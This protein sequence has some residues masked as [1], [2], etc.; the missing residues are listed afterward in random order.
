MSS[1]ELQLQATWWCNWK[2]RNNTLL[3]LSMERFQFALGDFCLKR[4]NFI[5][6]NR[7][8]KLWIVLVPLIMPLWYLI[9]IINHFVEIFAKS[10][11]TSLK[12]KKKKETNDIEMTHDICEILCKPTNDQRA[13]CRWDE[14]IRQLEL[15]KHWQLVYLPFKFYRLS[16]H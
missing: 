6:L 11:N 9:H 14:N 16:E 15:C 2:K 8:N 12:N 4:L 3:Q 7:Y 1:N 10:T 13:H 5:R